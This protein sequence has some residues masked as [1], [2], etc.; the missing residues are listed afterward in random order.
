MRRGEQSWDGAI[1]EAKRQLKVAR[2]R[3]EELERAIQT[4]R[5][6]KRNGQP[7]PQPA[8]EEAING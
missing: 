2:L 8:P 7:F 3:V 5:E 6:L 4:M 1:K